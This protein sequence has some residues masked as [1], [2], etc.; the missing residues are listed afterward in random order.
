MASMLGSDK[1]FKAMTK[2]AIMV[3]L[4]MPEINKKKQS[5][6]KKTRDIKKNQTE[7]SELKTIT[8]EMQISVHGLTSRTEATEERISG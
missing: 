6:G 4:V 5:L 2:N 3:I 1:D 7:N 8:T